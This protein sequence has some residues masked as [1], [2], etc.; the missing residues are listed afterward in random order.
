MNDR[1][2]TQALLLVLLHF[3]LACAI[4]WGVVYILDP[5]MDTD[6]SWAAILSNPA[7][8]VVKFGPTIAG[9]IMLAMFPVAGGYAGMLSRL[10]DFHKRPLALLGAL[11]VALIAAV[12]PALIYIFLLDPSVSISPLTLAGLSMAASWVGLRTLLGGGLGEEIGW[13]GFALPVLLGRIGPR[14][15]SLLLGVLWTI[16][17]LPA[18]F[19]EGTPWW[20]LAIA[21]GVLTI[22]LSFVFTWFYLR[23]GGSLSVAILLHGALN[24]FNAFVEKTWIPALDDAG[25]WQIVR[26]LFIL[27]LGLFAVITL[28]PK[29]RAILQG[30]PA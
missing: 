3:M 24:G 19:Q 9:L 4:S 2:L 13:R 12:V 28:P 25:E 23:S 22:S 20:L 30:A 6:D 15:A 10:F 29:R 21:Q 5:A 8:L 26:I 14:T 1:T 11:A 16:W 27:V 17:H 18:F 7:L